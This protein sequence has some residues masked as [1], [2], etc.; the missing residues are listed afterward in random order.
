[1]G[2]N[3]KNIL[4]DPGVSGARGPGG[5]RLRPGRRLVGRRGGD[6]RDDGWQTSFL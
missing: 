3:N 1:M 2:Q 5:Q 4:R 6:V